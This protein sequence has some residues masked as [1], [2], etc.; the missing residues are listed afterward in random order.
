MT[1]FRWNGIE[2]SWYFHN[3]CK[4]TY[5]EVESKQ[6]LLKGSRSAS[7][8]HIRSLEKE[9]NLIPEGASVNSEFSLSASFCIYPKLKYD[10]VLDPVEDFSWCKGKGCPPLTTD[11]QFPPLAA[12]EG[13]LSTRNSILEVLTWAGGGKWGSLSSLITILPSAE[14]FGKTQSDSHPP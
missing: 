6:A 11:F 12:S 8:F 5:S 7:L 14:I 3:T 13:F 10:D 1:P 2:N 4:Y 9:K